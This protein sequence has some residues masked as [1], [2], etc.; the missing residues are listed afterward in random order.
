MKITKKLSAAILA[1]SIDANNVL[2]SVEVPF[3]FRN[4]YV[5]AKTGVMGLKELLNDILQTKC[6][7]ALESP[8]SIMDCKSNNDLLNRAIAIDNGLLF[9]EIVDAVRAEFGPDRHPDKSIRVY[10]ND[11]MKNVKRIQ[12]ENHEDCNRPVGADKP[13]VKYYIALFEF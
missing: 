4:H 12:M 13:R 7:N 11:R 8:T 10:L 6:C 2:S 5:N 1:N 9:S 3:C